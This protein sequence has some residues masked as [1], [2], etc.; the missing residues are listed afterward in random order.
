M[1]ASGNY[2]LVP[3]LFQTKGA[4]TNVGV[5]TSKATDG[6]QFRYPWQ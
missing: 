2:V 5:L 6:E 3:A 4:L 1:E